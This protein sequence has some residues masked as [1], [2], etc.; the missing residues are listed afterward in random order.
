MAQFSRDTTSNTL[1]WRGDEPGA[2]SGLL[3]WR[4][5][6]KGRNLKLGL[7]TIQPRYDI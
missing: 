2:S 4:K 6:D 5:Q 1:T 3:T 7:G